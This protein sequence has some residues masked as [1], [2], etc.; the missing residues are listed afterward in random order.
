[1]YSP[2]QNI[3]RVITEITY[4]GAFHPTTHLI[5]HFIRREVI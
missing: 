1:M 5:I 3:K 4:T 2:L